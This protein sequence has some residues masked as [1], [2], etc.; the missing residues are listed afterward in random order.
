M[1]LA[2][3]SFRYISSL[4]AKVRNAMIASQTSLT[5]QYDDER[6]LEKVGTFRIYPY[7]Q[8]LQR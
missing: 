5:F 7:T 4:Q 3:T 1:I 8:L 6:L 2:N